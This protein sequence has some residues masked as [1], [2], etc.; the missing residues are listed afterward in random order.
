MTRIF[1]QTLYEQKD[2]FFMTK[3]IDLAQTAF[4][5]GEIP[6]GAIVVSAD[7][8]ILGADF[9]R[10]ENDYSQSSHAEINAISKAGKF[11]KNWR[12]DDCT[13][14]VTL[15][16]CLMCLGLIGLS[17]IKRIVY[18]A[19]SPLFGYHIDKDDIPELYIKHIKGI[20]KGVLENEIVAL[21]KSFFKMK[22]G[23]G[24]KV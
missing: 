14:Y 17:R 10:T 13:I 24:E 22:R 16:P 11:L 6:I 23:K 5:K 21:L 2:V 3:A 1:F 20:T 18:G 4:E 9:N 19:R 12:L 7:D 8:N 15:E